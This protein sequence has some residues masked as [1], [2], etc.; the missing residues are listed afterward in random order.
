MDRRNLIP[1]V[2]AFVIAA[3]L[4]APA[5]AR[6]G[7]NGCDFA[8]PKPLLK[9]HAYKG[10][11]FTRDEDNSAV[12][13]ATLAGGVT[14]TINIYQCIDQATD[15]FV[16]TAPNDAARQDFAAWT[17]FAQG[18]LS[19]LKVRDPRG[20]EA[21]IGFLGKARTMLPKDGVVAVCRNGQVPDDDECDWNS[22]GVLSIEVKPGA[23]TTQVTVTES[24]SG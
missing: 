24:E 14:L 17:D 12:E 21:L 5:M 9:S 18:V 1:A 13:T 4:L 6:A 7:D 22:G 11:H 15:E 10:Q 20:M 16:L 8:P 2:P 19:K 23:D 3:A